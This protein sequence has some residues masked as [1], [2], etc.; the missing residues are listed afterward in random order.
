MDKNRSCLSR[1]QQAFFELLRAGLW[2]Q[3]VRLSQL[4]KIEYDKVLNIAE[5]QSVIGLIAA[6]L[7]H[8]VD[9]IIPSEVIFQFVGQT[10]QLEKQNLAMNE[11]AAS[12]IDKLRKED[13]Y[14]ILVK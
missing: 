6:G 12:L 14:A 10:L 5:E 2:E 1:N 13:V 11:F 9:V 3:E 7:E 8:V 4:E